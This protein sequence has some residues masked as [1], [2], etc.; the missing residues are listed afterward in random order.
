MAVAVKE[1]LSGSRADFN[2]TVYEYGGKGFPRVEYIRQ[3]LIDTNP[4]ICPE[5][6]LLITESY[7]E[8]EGQPFVLRKARALANILDNMSIFI[9]DRQLIVGNQASKTR[10]APIFPE[11]SFDWVIKELDE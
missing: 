10:A 3:E 11:Y 1:S 2:Y 9:E 8:T 6:A 4:G 7:R 5:R